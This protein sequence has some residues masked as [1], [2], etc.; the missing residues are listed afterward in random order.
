MAFVNINQ[1]AFLS[2]E[3]LTQHPSVAS[4]ISIV[5][6]SSQ[7]DQWIPSPTPGIIAEVA[8]SPIEYD[9]DL[10]RPR[11]AGAGKDRILRIARD[12]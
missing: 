6:P 1:P 3:S 8:V 2:V 12:F 10:S 5:V 7:G 11:I 9:P 4:R